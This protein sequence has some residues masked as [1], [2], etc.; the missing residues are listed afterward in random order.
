MHLGKEKA[1]REGRREK[2]FS[3]TPQTIVMA[4]KI[5]LPGH[6]FVPLFVQPLVVPFYGFFPPQ[7]CAVSTL[8]LPAPCLCAIRAMAAGSQTISPAWIL[9]HPLLLDIR[10]ISDLSV[11]GTLASIQACLL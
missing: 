9:N 2:S 5:F 11:T 6:F 3:F 8:L 1:K 10:V 7:L 4:S